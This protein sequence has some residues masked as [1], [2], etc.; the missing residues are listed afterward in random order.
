MANNTAN[1]FTADDGKA[2]GNKNFKKAS[3]FLN[4]RIAVVNGTSPTVKLGDKGI[5]LYADNAV[6]KALIDAM[7]SGALTPETM[8]TLLTAELHEVPEESDEPIQFG[9]APKA[10]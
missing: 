10:P 3:A 6:H 5:P 8:I 1:K 9:F 4:F 2:T 7:K